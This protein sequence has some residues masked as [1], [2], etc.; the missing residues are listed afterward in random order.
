[1]LKYK[2]VVVTAL[3]PSKASPIPVDE[4]DVLT[5]AVGPYDSTAAVHFSSGDF[6]F[7]RLMRG[8]YVGQELMLQWHE[9]T[10]RVGVYAGGGFVASTADAPGTGL[11]NEALYLDGS[12]GGQNLAVLKWTGSDWLRVATSGNAELASFIPS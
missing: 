9:G 5:L 12:N 3:D 10:I 6:Y 1:M 4:V 11:T 7:V 2:T 8:L